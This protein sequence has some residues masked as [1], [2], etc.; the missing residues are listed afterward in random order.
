M[1]VWYVYHHM[2]AWYQG[3]VYILC[4]AKSNSELCFMAMD[5]SRV[6]SEWE[7]PLCFPYYL[8]GRQVSHIS[9]VVELCLCS[10]NLC[11]MPW[12]QDYFQ[13]CMSMSN[14]GEDSYEFLYHIQL[15]VACL[16]LL[17]LSNSIHALVMSSLHCYC[18]TKHDFMLSL[19]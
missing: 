13:D 7:N 5:G 2:I 10:L 4:G 9:L 1:I 12:L 15:S 19:L 8:C 11:C 16:G 14:S 6:W 17:N 3:N 18:H